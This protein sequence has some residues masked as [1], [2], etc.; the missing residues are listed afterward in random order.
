MT[1][2]YKNFTEA[3]KQLFNEDEIV[4]EVGP[5]IYIYPTISILQYINPKFYIAI[6][7][8]TSFDHCWQRFSQIGGLEEYLKRIKEYFG[9]VP[10]N[11]LSLS[12]LSH[13]LPLKSKSIDN[14]LFVKTLWK[15]TDGALNSWN[16]VKNSIID[17]YSKMGIS[18]LN[19]KEYK[20]LSILIYELLVLE[21][22]R[23]VGRKGIAIIPESESI[24][25]EMIKDLKI[26][27][28]IISDEFSISKVESPT[29]TI[30]RN[31][32]EVEIGHWQDNS[33]HSIIYF[34]M[35]GSKPISRDELIE[36]L[37]RSKYNLCESKY[38]RDLCYRLF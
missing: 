14:I 10:E 25:E 16:K 30:K 27:S 3:L 18:Y 11:L 36:Y 15:L 33:S 13:S 38:F 2:I 32:K 21:E 23:R 26:Y 5:G 20:Q 1:T 9:N 4:A 12:S 19:E 29:W 7:G 17:K 22:A 35:N 8:A 6:D 24:E 31:E 28:E 37:R 34:Y